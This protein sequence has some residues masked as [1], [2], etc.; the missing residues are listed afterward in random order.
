M[1]VLPSLLLCALFSWTLPSADMTADGWVALFDGETTFGWTSET[2]DAWTV[3]EGT[4]LGCG[5]ARIATTTEFKN[6]KVQYE[7]R[8]AA[9]QPWETKTAQIVDGALILEVPEGQAVSFRNVFFKPEGMKE[10]FNGKD[11]TGWKTYPEMDG[12]FTVNAEQK[13][14]E[15]KNGLGMLETEGTYG[16]FVFQSAVSL[17]PE[18]NSGFFFRCIPGEKLNGYECQLNNSVIDGDR[19][20]PKDAGSGAIF[21]RTVARYVPATDPE[22][23]R[24]TIIARGAHIATWV[25]GLQITDWTDERKAN[26]NPRRGLRVEPGTIMLQAHDV[27]TDCYFQDM[28]INS[29]D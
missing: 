19:T 15:A 21:R 18:V 12:K 1:N 10:I 7:T 20:Q 5:P 23:F 16:D 24:V 17:Q 27:T 14:L 22:L 4:L 28:K 29:W 6:G 25:N 8:C 3:E 11:L 26:P 9:C 13:R 2:P